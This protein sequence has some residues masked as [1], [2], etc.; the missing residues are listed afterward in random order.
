M[1]TIG[2]VGS[3]SW[4]LALSKVI[5]NGNLIV[6]TRDLKK[7]SK[8]FKKEENLEITDRFEDLSNCKYIFLAIPSQALR[9]NIKLIK[10]AM[11]IKNCI[12][13]ICS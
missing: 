13:I 7:A 9:Q 5:K 8:S 10:K 3:G 2:I 12:F 1:K 4:A 6:K 11:N